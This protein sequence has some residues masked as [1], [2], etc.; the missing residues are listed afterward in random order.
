M[1]QYLEL[2]YK[3]CQ[4]ASFPIFTEHNDCLPYAHEKSGIGQLGLS[5]PDDVV[6]KNCAVGQCSL[7]VYWEG[8]NVFWVKAIIAFGHHCFA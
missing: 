6:T 7:E 5:E 1:L 2:L 3:I 8:I 4:L